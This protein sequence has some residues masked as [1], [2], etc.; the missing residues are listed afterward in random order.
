MIGVFD[1]GLGGLS[2]LAAIRQRMPSADLL[3]VADRGRAPFGG[4]SLDEVMTISHEIASWLV[5]HGSEL[6]VVACNTASAAALKSLRSEFDI[7]IVGMEPAVK[8]AAESTSTGTVGVFA[9]A[10]T[11]QGRLFESVVDRHASDVEVLT[12]AC[13]EWVEIV[14]SGRI[15]GREVERLVVE[16]VEPMVEQG[17]DVLVL[18]CTHFSFISEVI[19]HAAGEAVTV[20]DPTSAVAAQTERVSTRTSG[21]GLVQLA[22]SGDLAEFASLV[23][24]LVDLKHAGVVLPFTP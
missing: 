23:R 13:P 1:S 16:A 20:I 5:D 11:F 8:P 12:R 17:A 6:L 9:T 19:S 7:P 18:G 3:Y 14:E 21:S 4:R 10:A 24:Q 22:A 2:I 15:N